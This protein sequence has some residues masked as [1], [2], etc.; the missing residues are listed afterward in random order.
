MK[1]FI[2]AII[3]LMSSVPVNEIA[4]STRIPT[5]SK[6]EYI[7]AKEDGINYPFNIQV[8]YG[9]SYWETGTYIFSRSLQLYGNG[10]MLI[11]EK[12]ICGTEYDYKF[13]SY[14]DDA[15]SKTAADEIVDLGL[16]ESKRGKCAS[17]AV[18]VVQRSYYLSLRIA[19]E[20]YSIATWVFE[21][22]EPKWLPLVEYMRSVMGEY[23]IDDNEISGSEYLDKREEI[24]E[25]YGKHGFC[26][27][28]A[29]RSY[30]DEVEAINKE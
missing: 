26:C 20:Y 22:E 6:D 30:V 15:L 2:L 28:E 3:I 18:G 29:V 11:V 21:G 24:I 27:D 25:I 7:A 4:D 23:I 19:E 12:E 5:L 8:L 14:H 17:D 9:E 13:Y 1:L 16:F 10:M